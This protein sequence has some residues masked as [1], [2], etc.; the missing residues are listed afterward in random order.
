M[1]LNKLLQI[2]GLNK[3]LLIESNWTYDLDDIP[4]DSV[5]IDS[6]NKKRKIDSFIKQLQHFGMTERDIKNTISEIDTDPPTYEY[7]NGAK[8]WRNEQG[9]LHRIGGKPAR[10]D[11]YEKYKKFKK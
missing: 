1:N 11:S 5:N 4:D 2:A 10:I 7:V 8:E 3:E 9:D 6:G